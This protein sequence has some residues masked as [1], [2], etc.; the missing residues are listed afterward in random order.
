MRKFIFYYLCLFN[1]LD[2]ILALVFRS[3]TGGVDAG[4]HPGI[5]IRGLLVIYL[6]LYYLFY[7]NNKMKY[8]SLLFPFVV[9]LLFFY[10]PLIGAINDSMAGFINEY[11]KSFKI[12]FFLLMI[13]YISSN[14]EY[15]KNKFPTIMICNISFIILKH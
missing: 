2:Y 13:F 4:V 11:I 6:F 1:V 9:L 14:Q 12:I 7:K 3:D 15:F 5:I 10:H 8:Y